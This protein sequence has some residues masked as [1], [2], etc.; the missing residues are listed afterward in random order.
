[1][2]ILIRNANIIRAGSGFAGDL[3]IRNGKIEKI[4]KELNSHY[5]A[6]R[7]LDA[8]GLLV[9]PGGVDPHVHMHL[10]TGA[11]FSSDDFETG[12]EAALHGGTTTIIDFVTPEKGMPL[13]R[14]LELRKK[15]AEKSLTDYSFHVSP[16]EWR[17]T[18]A[19][20]IKTCVSSGITSFKVY[21]A[22]KDAIGLDDK[23]LE[24]VMEAAAGAGGMV[25][26][27]CET[28]DEVDALRD[29][30]F[31][32]GKTSPAA[33]PVSRPAH[34]ESD[35]VKKAIAIARKTSCPL[36]VVH[37]SAA[38]SLGHIRRAQQKGQ[39]VFGEVCPHH[40][41]L[42]DT[43]YQGSFQEAAPYVLS[44]PLRK[45]NDRRA[46]WEAL[47][48]QT[49]EVAAT[50]HCPFFMKQKENGLTDFRK[51]ANG[52]G[53]VEHRLA[54]LYTYGV[55]KNRISLN[56]FV[57]VTSTAPAKIFGLYPQ[58]GEIAEG[59]DAD[60]VI[61]EPWKKD[62]IS[63]KTHHQHSDINIYEGMQTLGRPRYV[64]AGGT[65]VIEKGEM[66]SR[67]TGKFLERRAKA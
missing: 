63:A 12:S 57:E 5:N 38:A 65:V 15:E 54:L 14:A 32:E 6:D 19:E 17:E 34:T 18:T 27:H 7:T 64:I 66:V 35:A 3:L 29:Q 25:T 48:D 9:F 8:E 4:G 55:M 16:V 52:A 40:L 28:G 45:K 43:L 22:Y 59:S 33:H 13:T 37:V 44:P 56:R 42:D 26:V 47:E 67:P 11:G 20:E 49:L 53:G 36:Y 30:L 41:L 2:S 60:L 1:M 10:P 50:D 39:T 51:I 61:W 58:K 31:K 24:K 62:V 23:T 46:L 21:M